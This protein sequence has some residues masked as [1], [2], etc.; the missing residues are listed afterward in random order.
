MQADRLEQVVTGLCLGNSENFLVKQVNI[1][2][3]SQPMVPIDNG[4]G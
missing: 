3:A 2:Y 4:E 1:D